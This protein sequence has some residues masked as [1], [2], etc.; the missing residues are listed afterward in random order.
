MT[1]TLPSH[2]LSIVSSQDGM[3]AVQAAAVALGFE[4]LSALIP[5][6]II[7]I[8][9]VCCY[10]KRR[11]NNSSQTDSATLMTEVTPK[12]V[13]EVQGQVRG[14]SLVINIEHTDEPVSPKDFILAVSEP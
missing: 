5:V 14:D 8:L 13:G 12:P 11:K 2:H 3:G 4:W 10:R 9:P 1:S 6:I 7:F